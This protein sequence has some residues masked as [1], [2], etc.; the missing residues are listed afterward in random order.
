MDTQHQKPAERIT[1]EIDLSSRLLSGVEVSSATCSATNITTGA[2]DNAVL[3]STT[4]SITST[5]AKF[6]VHNMV[7]QRHYK[8]TVAATLSNSDIIE[9][10]IEIRCE[11]V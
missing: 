1:Y 2:T 5:A 7:S 3:V 4:C 10:D 9:E 11:A 8:V 6:T